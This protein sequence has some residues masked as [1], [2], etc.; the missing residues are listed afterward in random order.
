MMFAIVLPMH[1]DLTNNQGQNRQAGQY[2]LRWR[3]HAR[4]SSPLNNAVIPK[5]DQKI[6]CQMT[7]ILHRR[8]C[9]RQK[10]KQQKE[11]N[12]QAS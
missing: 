4:Q 10:L 2:V 6:G 3:C 8:G 11:G 5:T 12:D 9:H 1:Q 7:M